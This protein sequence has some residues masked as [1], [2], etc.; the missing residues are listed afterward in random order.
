MKFLI[1]SMVLTV[2][3][4]SQ[5]GTLEIEPVDQKKL[6]FILSRV[7]EDVLTCKET[8]ISKPVKGKSVRRQFSSGPVRFDCTSL[9]Y[10]KSPHATSATCEVSLDPTAPGATQVNDEIMVKITNRAQAKA[11]YD[12]I[13]YGK[14]EKAIWSWERDS[15]R[16]SEGFRAPI[17]HYRMSCLPTECTFIF[18]AK[19]LTL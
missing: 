19:K 5:A 6:A 11:F 18:S 2:S 17:F 13:P 15:G 3:M 4:V 16:N 10:Q 9:H 7:S 14:P 12:A 8:G 1:A